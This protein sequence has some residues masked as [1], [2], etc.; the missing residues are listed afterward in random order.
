MTVL[1]LDKATMTE[2]LDTGAL[3]RR[4]RLRARGEVQGLE[5]QVRN[6]G[7]RQGITMKNGHLRPGGAGLG[8]RRGVR[9]FDVGLGR[10]RRR[11]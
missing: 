6:S 1:V 2:G 4:A 5:Q 7:M 3:D 8:I 9:F 11:R 10:R